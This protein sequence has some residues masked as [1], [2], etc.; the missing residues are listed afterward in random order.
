MR[1]RQLEILLY[2]MERK[3]STYAELAQHYEVSKKTIMRDIDKISDMGVPVY[4]QP[5]YEGGV[6]LAPGYRFSRSFFTAREIEEII[7][8]F[9]I[10]NHLDSR[11]GKNS[12]LKK[13]ELLMPELT[14]LKEFDFDEYLK[15]ELLQKPVSARTPVCEVINTG[16][17]D[18]IFLDLTADGERYIVAPLYYILRLDGLYLYCTDENSFF[19][20]KIEQISRC[21][22]TSREFDRTDYL[23]ESPKK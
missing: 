3:K 13:L 19:T 9:H 15:I 21:E 7:L 1:S 17:D 8:A 12:A 14:F 5:G 23:T 22:K 11:N 6:F 18:E 16:L 4:T 2:L 10:V 20:L